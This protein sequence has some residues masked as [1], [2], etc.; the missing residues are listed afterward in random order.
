MPCAYRRLNARQNSAKYLRVIF[1]MEFVGEDV[2]LAIFSYLDVKMLCIASQVCHQWNEISNSNILWKSHV[3]QLCKRRKISAHLGRAEDW[4]S[5]YVQLITGR[6]YPRSAAKTEKKLSFEALTAILVPVEV[7]KFVELTIKKK[8]P[9]RDFVQGQGYTYVVGRAFYQHTKS[10][11]I[12]MKKRILL[13]E[14]ESGQLF[15]GNTVRQILGL[16]KGTSDWNIQPSNFDSRI[17]EFYRVFV[18]STS[19]NRALVSNTVL[20]YQTR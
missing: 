7:E 15:E 14:K 6:L 8:M 16:T 5:R 3:M 12:S 18:Q 4:K 17:S 2:L 11:T 19:V 20:L 1:T 9:I 13:Q 10:E